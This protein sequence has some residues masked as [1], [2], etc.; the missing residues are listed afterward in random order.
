MA[1]ARAGFFVSLGR[2][3][4]ER[5]QQLYM[6]KLKTYN[7]DFQHPKLYPFHNLS[8]G[9]ILKIFL[10]FRKFHPRYS[11]EIHSY[12]K[13][14]VLCFLLYD[15]R[16]ISGR[17]LEIHLRSQAK[18]FKDFLINR[19]FHHKGD[20]QNETLVLSLFVVVL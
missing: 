14:R 15:R 2:F 20:F 7:S 9:F 17:R 3:A 5:K 12:K 6:V 19:L 10:K 16:R 8:L 18:C 4:F 11:Y 1:I 13:E